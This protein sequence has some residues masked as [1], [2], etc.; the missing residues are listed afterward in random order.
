[1][2]KYSI[3]A[4]NLLCNGEWL[5]N[6][7]ICVENGKVAS[8]DDYNAENADYKVK[9]LTN[10][11]IDNHTHG[12]DGFIASS[13][14]EKALIEWLE[15]LSCNGV[16]GVALTLYGSVGTIRS[17]LEAIKTVMDAQKNGEVKGALLLGAHL[18]APF[19]SRERPGSM[20][21]DAFVAPS[22]EEYKAMVKG[23]E[24]A[25]KEITLAPELDGADELIR[26]LKE[27][28]I[29]VLAGHSDCSYEKANEAF[30]NGVG[31]VCHTFN[32]IRPIHHREPGVVTAALT[33]PEIYCE[34]ICDLEHLHPGVIKLIMLCKGKEK[35]MVISDSV[36]TTNLPD[37]EYCVDGEPIVVKD[38]ISRHKIHK[39]LDGG[40][41]YISKSVKNLVNIG[42]SF[43]DAVT[44]AS[45]TPANWLGFDVNKATFLQ[46]WND[47]FIPQYTF[48]GNNI[49]RYKF[50]NE[51]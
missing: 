51:Q 25:V 15:K 45:I 41:C 18:E 40:G 8:V 29:R 47:D 31:A 2:C 26:Y 14:G 50:N 13:R 28:D 48:I 42:I 10:A 44:S 46:G 21:E 23:Y 34:A 24:E 33:N 6:K 38:G 5:K 36:T 39:C 49:Y 37:G 12:G 11:L 27:N 30:K 43:E 3:Y 17:G 19:I 7:L 32:A 9:Y 1:M 16:G 4:E 20:P 35:V 22:I